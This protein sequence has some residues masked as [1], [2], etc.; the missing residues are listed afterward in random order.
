M[1]EHTK[2]RYMTVMGVSGLLMR[3]AAMTDVIGAATFPTPRRIANG[4]YALRRRMRNKSSI[5]KKGGDQ[6]N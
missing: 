3:C 1:T 4:E 5:G 6:Y 2:R